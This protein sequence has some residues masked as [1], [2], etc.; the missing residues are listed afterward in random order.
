MQIL[1]LGVDKKSNE[2]LPARRHPLYSPGMLGAVSVYLLL[3]FL[4]YLVGWQPGPA[5]L[6]LHTSRP[7]FIA[8]QALLVLILCWLS[9]LAC[10]PAGYRHGR[11]AAENATNKAIGWMLFYPG[12]LFAFLTLLLLIIQTLHG[13]PWPAPLLAALALL[14][15]LRFWP[16]SFDLPWLFVHV[17]PPRPLAATTLVDFFALQDGHSPVSADDDRQSLDPNR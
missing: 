12:T 15:P 10:S 6:D 5:W 4:W 2:T 7:N 9:A 17:H 3:S 11:A 1:L 16:Q 14:V 8:I 13:H